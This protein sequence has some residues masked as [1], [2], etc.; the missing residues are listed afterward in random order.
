MNEE[1]WRS[2]FFERLNTDAEALKAWEYLRG[3]DCE[4]E[5]LEEILFYCASSQD[6]MSQALQ[7][8]KTHRFF[9][10]LIAV[11]CFRV[12]PEVL[13]EIRMYL[14]PALR[15]KL[16]AWEKATLEL[17][18][19]ILSLATSKELNPKIAAFG[20]PLLVCYVSKRCQRTNYAKIASLVRCAQL[21]F[22]PKYKSDAPRKAVRRYRID[23]KDAWTAVE[24][25]VE[26]HKKGKPPKL[27]FSVFRELETINLKPLRFYDLKFDITDVSGLRRSLEKAGIEPPWRK[28][29]L[30]KLLDPRIET[31]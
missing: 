9:A 8:A 1:V 27:V 30:T 31:D 22:D 14:D 28:Q 20:V 7:L 29:L 25:A 6:Q 18:E 23:Y 2:R 19:D 12:F 26:Q 13:P 4:A 21:S 16:V 3:R 24:R 17:S 10:M 11:R 15:A 5:V